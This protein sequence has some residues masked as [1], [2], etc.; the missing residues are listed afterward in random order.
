MKRISLCLTSLLLLTTALLSQDR[1]DLQELSKE[2]DRLD[3]LVFKLG[4]NQCDTAQLRMIFS[5]DLEFFHDQNGFLNSKEMLLA[6]IPDL[7]NMSYK[8]TR[9]R[10]DSSMQVFPL[11]ANGKL[12]GVIQTGVHQFYGEEAN[13]PKYL[14]STAKFTHVWILEEDQWRLNRILSYDHQTPN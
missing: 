12:Y 13:K 10:I 7:C 1:T 6:S 8:A 9:E 3:S 5:E 4:Y 2:L 11:Y 14:T